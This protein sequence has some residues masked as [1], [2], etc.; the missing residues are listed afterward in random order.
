MRQLAEDDFATLP[1]TLHFAGGKV[2]LGGMPPEWSGRSTFQCEHCMS[3]IRTEPVAT[4]VMR[5]ESVDERVEAR[6][7]L[8]FWKGRADMF[9]RDSINLT[10]ITERDRATEAFLDCA[11]M[12]ALYASKA[13]IR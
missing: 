3:I 11:K 2:S 13:G 10:T 12:V 8:E 4:G 5:A 1:P 9:L 6:R 7:L